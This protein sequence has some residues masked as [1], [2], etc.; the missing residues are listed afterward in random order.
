[1]EFQVLNQPDRNKIPMQIQMNMLQKTE[2]VAA[3]EI[4]ARPTSDA[5]L[6]ACTNLV[7]KTK[8]LWSFATYIG[9][10]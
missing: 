5:F 9:I 8:P 4:L 7:C 6:N 3:T 10:W 2:K 1:M